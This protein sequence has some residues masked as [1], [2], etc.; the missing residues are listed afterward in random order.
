MQLV[1]NIQGKVV[2]RPYPKGKPLQR[3][4]MVM[5]VVCCGHSLRLGI[6]ADPASLVFETFLKCVKTK[7]KN[8][9]NQLLTK[10]MSVY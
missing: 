2:I 3:V 5:S 6:L 8:S 9:V 1:A 7:Q 10:N 4:P